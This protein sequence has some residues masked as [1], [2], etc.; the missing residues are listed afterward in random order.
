MPLGSRARRY[1]PLLALVALGLLA[2]VGPW[3]APFDPRAQPDPVSLALLPPSWA[4]PFGTDPLS[5]DVLSRVLAGARVSLGIAFSAVLVAVTLG[6]AVGAT[7]A[8][9]G[10][11]I[12]TVLMRVTDAAMAIPRLLL[13]LT[14]VA[15]FGS[16]TPLALALLLGATGWMTTARLVRQETHRLLG[17]EFVRGARALGVPA[18]RLLRVHLLP[19][20]LPTIG[21]AATVALA[22]AVPLEA[23]LSFLGLGVGPP[24]ASWGN[25][26]LEAEGEVIRRWWLVLFPTLAI[27]ATVLTTNVVA[28]RLGDAPQGDDAT[29]GGAS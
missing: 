17:S 11:W 15:A 7:A 6:T 3:L 29:D 22:A 20:L 2:L 28:E 23:G 8:L 21:V 4:H 1:A 18:V 12:D 16:V 26:I 14:A 24:N 13:L 25:I 19:A 9:A 5:R 10:R 27:V